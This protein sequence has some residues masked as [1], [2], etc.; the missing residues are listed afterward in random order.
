MRALN[1]GPRAAFAACMLA[2]GAYAAAAPEP[3]AAYSAQ[4]DFNWSGEME[5]GAT[6]RIYSIAGDITVREGSGRTARITGRT[7]P[8]ETGGEIEYVTERVEGGIRVCALR[9]G[10]TCGDNGVRT[11]NNAWGRGRRA[12]ADFV[13]ELPRGVQLRVGTGNGAVGVDGA[14]AEVHAGTGNGDVRV[15]A[16][17][18]RVHASTGNGAVRVDGARG[19][20]D[21][22]TGN[23]RVT[24]ST[25]RGP[26]EASTGNGSIDVTMRELTGRDNLHFSSGNGSITL[27]LPADFSA[28]VE[29]TTGNG[30]VESDFPVQV[31]GRI[32]PHRMRGTIGGGGRRLN[33]STGNGRI[34]L[35]RG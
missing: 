13:V 11:R 27:T 19:P 16:G 34:V 25:E 20:V 18:L 33:I 6:L 9:D 1:A 5:A 17:A 2:A 3:S 21:A 31:Q 8:G 23:G 30:G 22:S 29:A 4:R 12:R 7:T 14:T 10:A 35:R 26:V 15:G 32:T 24:V 28:E